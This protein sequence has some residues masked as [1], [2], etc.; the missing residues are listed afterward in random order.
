ML[1][2]PQEH[3]AYIS[4]SQGF[5][6]GSDGKESFCN[7]GDMSSI[8]GFG[9]S[10]GE[11]NSKPIQCSWL[12][13]YMNSGDWW[14]TGQRSRIV[15]YDWANNT[16]IN[17]VFTSNDCYLPDS[18]CLLSIYYLSVYHI[19]RSMTEFQNRHKRVNMLLL[20]VLRYFQILQAHGL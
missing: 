19:F 3:L 16:L 7:S 10:L 5:P 4:R 13:N 15:R 9:R 12:E 14:A 18:I 1:K 6:G 11:R 2:N 8:P 17:V 20:L